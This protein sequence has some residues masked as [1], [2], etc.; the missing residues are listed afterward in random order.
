M[1]RNTGRLWILICIL[2][3]PCAAFAQ[4]NQTSWESLSALAPGHKIQVVERN[5]KKVSGTF[6]NVSDAAI[7]LQ[8]QGGGQTIQRQDVRIVK[9]ME[10]EHRLRH[11]AIGAAIGAGAGA[12][13]G[14]GVYTDCKPDETFCINPVG[15][16]Q[17]AGI[18]AAVGGAVG[19]IV[20]ALW[21]S[22][23]IV[24]RATGH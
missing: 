19:A 2:V 10:N 14:A 24:Y 22:Q 15:R 4:T 7:S 13:I 6:V 9:L 18:G 16:G 21:P 12:G 1:E 3:M 17:V 20:G 11:A 8:E 23:K 5:S